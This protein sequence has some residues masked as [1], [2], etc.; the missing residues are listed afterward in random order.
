VADFQFVFLGLCWELCCAICLSELL[1]KF[2]PKFGLFFPHN[3]DEASKEMVVLKMSGCWSA[4]VVV[5]F[6]LQIMLPLL[7]VNLVGT[8]S[9]RFVIALESIC[10]RPDLPLSIQAVLGRGPNARGQ[11]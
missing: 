5:E 3:L 7:R 10:A 2:H 8:E 4:L 9:I 6:I 1:L 11:E